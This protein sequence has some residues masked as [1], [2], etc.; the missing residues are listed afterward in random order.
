MKITG[1]PA[2]P[3]RRLST[4]HSSNPSISGMM[5]SIRMMSGVIRS[6]IDKAKEADCA[7]RTV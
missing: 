4:R 2:R 1:T 6:M 5:A 7:S 3:A